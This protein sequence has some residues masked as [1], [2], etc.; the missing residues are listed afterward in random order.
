MFQLRHE[1]DYAIQFLSLLAKSKTKLSLNDVAFET[2]ISF[3]FLQKIA[4]KLRLAGIIKADQGVKGGYSLAV[5]ARSL[6]LKNI[7]VAIE[8]Q[9]GLVSCCCDNDCKCEKES[10]CKAKKKLVQVSKQIT[11]ILEK[12]KLTAI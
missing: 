2:G 3:L 6:N 5:P 9:C 11:K 12:V 4:R 10:I 7:V 1:T 8:G